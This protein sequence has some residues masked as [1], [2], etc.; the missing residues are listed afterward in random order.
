MTDLSPASQKLLREIAKYDT[1]AGVLFRHAPRGRYSHPNTLMTYNM[2]TFWPLTGL[3]LV[4]DGG[5]DSA[6]VRITE[7]GQK[8]AAE[9]EEQ[10][11]TQQAAKK[12]RPK[13]SADGATALRL[14]R[15]IAKHDGSLIYDD[16]LRRVWRVAS[17]DGHRAS[18][19]IWVA[20]EKAGYIRTERV[21]SIGGQRVSIT[22]AGRQRIAPA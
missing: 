3:G 2:R 12:A 7:A 4:D 11:K 16:G 6:P 1:G 8:L 22:D 17:R 10:H 19:G 5:N 21:S 15:E 13:P 20:L 9:L 14:L 18:I